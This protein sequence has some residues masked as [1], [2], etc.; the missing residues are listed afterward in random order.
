MRFIETIAVA[1]VSLGS[2]DAVEVSPVLLG[3]SALA[4]LDI[5]LLVVSL[6]GPHV[7]NILNCW[8]GGT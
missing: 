8:G 6:F 4:V 5:L 7:T 3:F 1:V 2:V